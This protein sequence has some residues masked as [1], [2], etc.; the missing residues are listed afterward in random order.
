MRP[1]LRLAGGFDPFS[2]GSLLS[3]PYPP[4]ESQAAIPYKMPVNIIVASFTANRS[5]DLDIDLS[6]YF[7]NSSAAV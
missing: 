5:R 4:H 7:H 2:I 3:H 6:F 1:L